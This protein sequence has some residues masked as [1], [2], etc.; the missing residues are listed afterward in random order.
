MRSEAIAALRTELL[1]HAKADESLC[2]VASK[3]GIFCK[4]FKQF[5]DEELFK[6][7][8]WMA[9]KLNITSREDLETYANLWQVSQQQTTGLATACD[10][11]CEE[12]DTCNGWDTFNNAKLALFMYQV[13]HEKVRVVDD[14]KQSHV[15]ICSV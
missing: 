11:Q 15:Q 7:Y 3:E 12:H 13:C 8:D 14:K 2:E 5:S 10:V 6:Q 4:G 9:K 1:K